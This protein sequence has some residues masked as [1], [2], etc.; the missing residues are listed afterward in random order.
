MFWLLKR[1]KKENSSEL[2]ISELNY[3]EKKEKNLNK[4]FI[5]T[6]YE[7]KKH[8]LFEYY[9]DDSS[10]KLLSLISNIS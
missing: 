4:K 5:S 1:N 7:Y 3:Q 9:E 8:S 2:N 6:N 10:N